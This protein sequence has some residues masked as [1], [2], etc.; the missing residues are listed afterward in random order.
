MS[1]S[2]RSSGMSEM[3]CCNGA[4]KNRVQQVG[5]AFAATH[6]YGQLSACSW[7]LQSLP[8]CLQ[9]TRLRTTAG[10]MQAHR[11]TLPMSSVFVIHSCWHA[12]LWLYVCTAARHAVP[13]WSKRV[14]NR[15]H[16][17]RMPPFGP[18]PYCF[19]TFL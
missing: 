9:D 6:N 10:G 8:H 13:T 1:S 18:S 2:S 16:E 19:I 14:A 7:C 12:P 15:L 17:V 5:P 11:P 3:S 4:D